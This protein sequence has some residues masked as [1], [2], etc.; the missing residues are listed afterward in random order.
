MLGCLILKHASD[1][2]HFSI[3]SL[4]QKIEV[5]WTFVIPTCSRFDVA[6]NIVVLPISGSYIN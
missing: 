6:E 3:E 2:N 4:Y 1:A 5:S